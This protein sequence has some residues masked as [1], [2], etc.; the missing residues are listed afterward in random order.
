MKITK[1]IEKISSASEDIF[2]ENP[3]SLQ[4]LHRVLAQYAKGA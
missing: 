4:F 3:G 1:R 2:G